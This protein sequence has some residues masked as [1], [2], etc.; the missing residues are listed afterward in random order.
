MINIIE[1][2]NLPIRYVGNGAWWRGKMNPDFKVTGQNKVIETANGAFRDMDKYA[3]ERTQAF[4][5]L[6]IKCLVLDMDKLNKKQILFSTNRFI[7]NG[8]E[9][10]SIEH[11]GREGLKVFNFSCHP[12]NSYIVNGFVTH[13]CDDFYVTDVPIIK[14]WEI[15]DLWDKF[16]EIWKPVVKERCPGCLWNTHLDSHL[17]KR[18]LLPLTDYIHGI[19]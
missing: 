6:G 9:I 17:I 5:K 3:S 18:G 12:Y 8:S 4:A 15:A 14:I 7:N 2:N 19:L 16:C 1:E 10:I 13:N 11:I